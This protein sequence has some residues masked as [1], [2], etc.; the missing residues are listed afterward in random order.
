MTELRARG[1]ARSTGAVAL[2]GYLAAAAAVGCFAL[3]TVAVHRGRAVEAT[4][5]RVVAD[6]GA[7]DRSLASADFAS[8]GR[9]R[10]QI[11]ELAEVL[12]RLRQA[13]Q[14]DLELLVATEDEL[15]RLV[16]AGGEHQRLAAAMASVAG[17]L[18]QNMAA[19]ERVAGSGEAGTE[20]LTRLLQRAHEVLGAINAELAAIEA[21]LGAVPEP[22]I[23]G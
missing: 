6:V 19:I 18:A 2:V 11:G 21:Q 16:A 20:E 4:S 5:E 17:Q 8:A 22:G 10:S 23:R 7:A 12:A 13:T 1:A 9:A 3:A 15:R 14:K